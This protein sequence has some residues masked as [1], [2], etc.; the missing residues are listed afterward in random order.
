MTEDVTRVWRMLRKE[1]VR[2]WCLVTVKEDEMGEG[3]STHVAEE[4]YIHKLHR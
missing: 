3:C 1:E 2:N 4:R